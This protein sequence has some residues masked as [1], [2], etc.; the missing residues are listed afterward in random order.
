MRSRA[1]DGLADL[2]VGASVEPLVGIRVVPLGVDHGHARIVLVVAGPTQEQVT[3]VVGES[4]LSRIE[5]R[6][7]RSVA[8]RGATEF[9]P[10]CAV[11]LQQVD[12]PNAADLLRPGHCPCAP[13]WVTARLETS[14][15]EWDN[16]SP[17]ALPSMGTQ[18]VPLNTRA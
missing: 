16:P 6:V 7:R 12:L 8:G 10:G 17:L 18:F 15:V 1:A 5:T 13:L 11:G 3:R 9:L 4:R 14:V 2:N